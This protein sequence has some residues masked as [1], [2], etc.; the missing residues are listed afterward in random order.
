MIREISSS[1]AI[2]LERFVNDSYMNRGGVA[3]KENFV[4]MKPRH[5]WDTNY[6]LVNRDTMEDYL[7]DTGDIHNNIEEVYEYGGILREELMTLDDIYEIMHEVSWSKK[8]W[9]W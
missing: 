2:M 9:E 1:E 4:L 7:I 3:E 8:V 5:T 6:H